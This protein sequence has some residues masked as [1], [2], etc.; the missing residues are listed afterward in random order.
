M[1]DFFLFRS[2]LR[3]RPNQARGY[4][5]AGPMFLVVVLSFSFILYQL[6]RIYHKETAAL[7]QAGQ[8]SFNGT[9]KLFIRACKE[10]D[11]YLCFFMASGDQDPEVTRT[12]LKKYV[13]SLTSIRKKITA[14]S[15]TVSGFQEKEV[16]DKLL[17][18]M[19]TALR[20][21]ALFLTTLEHF[22]QYNE[23]EHKSQS[24]EGQAEYFRT[25]EN[26]GR[27]ADYLNEKSRDVQNK[28]A[29]EKE[30]MAKVADDLNQL[31]QD[32]SAEITAL[33]HYVPYFDLQEAVLFPLTKEKLAKQ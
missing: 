15:L 22:S 1:K 13:S 33:Y 26:D 30:R 11:G 4:V 19:N 21:T 3:H 5:R 2:R 12:A 16:L 31:T 32:L 28:G 18:L 17:G 25:E 14:N 7:T 27:L 9:K 24:L 10:T 23:L 8:K 6:I 20:H 29:D